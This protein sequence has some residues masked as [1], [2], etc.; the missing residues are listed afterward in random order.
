MMFTHVM[1][2]SSDVERSR[3]FYDPVMQALGHDAGQFD[4]KRLF[5]GGFGKGGA[6]GVG[7]PMNGEPAS[8]GNGTMAGFAARDVDAVHAWHAAGLANGGTCEGEPGPRGLP[9]SYGAYLRDPDGNKLS[10]FC[11]TT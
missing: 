1:V 7:A 11:R 10:A 9:G 8:F 2:G 6:F 3:A 5:Y 4:G